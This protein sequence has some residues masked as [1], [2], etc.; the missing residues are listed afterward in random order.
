MI[1]ATSSPSF[2]GR[3]FGYVARD[4]KTQKHKCHVFRCDMPARAVARALLESHQREKGRLRE[5]PLTTSGSSMASTCTISG[6]SGGV[7]VCVCEASVFHSICSLV[8]LAQPS[9][10][11]T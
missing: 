4:P 2:P 1:T 11:V 9:F 8:Q 7:C 5:S 3:E 6:E 10:S